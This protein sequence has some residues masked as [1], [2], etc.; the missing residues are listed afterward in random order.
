MAKTSYDITPC[1]ATISLN[2]AKPIHNGFNFTA[3]NVPYFVVKFSDADNPFSA[4]TESFMVKG[5]TY[6]KDAQVVY[7]ADRDQAIALALSLK[8]G[9]MRPSVALNAI[10]SA[11]KPL[12]TKHIEDA[13]EYMIGTKPQTVYSKVFTKGTPASVLDAEMDRQKIKYNVAPVAP[14]T[15]PADAVQVAADSTTPF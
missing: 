5:V 3:D 1:D 13:C 2:E 11:K 12:F 8:G 15:T 4:K 10:N 9:F 14:V 7:P 6:N